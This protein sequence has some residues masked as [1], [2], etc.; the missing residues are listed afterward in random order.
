MMSAWTRSDVAYKQIMNVALVIVILSALAAH[1][2]PKVSIIAGTITIITTIAAVLLYIWDG[3]SKEGDEKRSQPLASEETALDVR[4]SVHVEAGRPPSPVAPEPEEE[5]ATVERARA[6]L[7][8]RLALANEELSARAM[9][10]WDAAL[11]VE[12]KNVAAWRTQNYRDLRSVY[13]KAGPVTWMR[14]IETME[15][16]KA[17]ATGKVVVVVGSLTIEINEEETKIHVASPKTTVL[18]T[19]V[20]HNTKTDDHRERDVRVISSSVH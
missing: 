7:A 1:E 20:S 16:A 14:E 12:R 11:T 8:A 17:N 2:W 18:T 13:G 6:V 5:S 19:S 10:Y 9:R 15:T 3:K 4:E